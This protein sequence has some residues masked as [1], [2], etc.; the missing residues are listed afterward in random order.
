MANTRRGG[1]WCLRVGAIVGDVLR[2]CLGVLVLVACERGEQ[3]PTPPL[4]PSSP[5]ASVVESAP[6]ESGVRACGE[7]GATAME[8]PSRVAEG[9]TLV[10]R[11][12]LTPG[13]SLQIG[14]VA[15]RYDES[16]WIGTRRAGT[17]GPGLNVEI[18][19]AEVGPHAPWGTLEALRPAM[20]QALVVGPYRVVVQTGAEAP[21]AE[22]VVTVTREVCPAAAVIEHT[23]TPQWL[24]LSSEGIRVHSYDVAGGL[25]QVAMYPRG[26]EPRVEVTQRSYRHWFE[27]RPGADR[28]IRAGAYAVSFD[29]VLAGPGTRFEGRWVAETEAR[30][31]V[32]GR[33]EAAARASFPAAQ[34][35]ATPCGDPSPSRML[36]PTPLGA[37]LEIAETLRLR[38]GERAKMGPI[39][40]VFGTL[41]VPA[42]GHGVYRKEGYSVPNLQVFALHGGSNLTGP[43]PTARMLRV[44]QALLRVIGEGES[45]RVDRV[46]LACA[47]ELVVAKPTEPVYL[48]LGTNGH[49]YV[50]AG[51]FD[52]QALHLQVFLEHEASLGLSSER[53]SLIQAL[54]GELVGLGFTFD[55]HL[56]EVVEVQ[57][58]AAGPDGLPPA[59]HVQLRVT[60]GS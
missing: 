11:G 47:S 16:A 37:A 5:P 26:V 14:K 2:G 60:P 19:R 24:W 53:G 55:E 7:A 39:E 4:G 40:L 36:L 28:T 15:L 32:R 13:G 58:G 35:A 43:F 20:A 56:V 57:E 29:R 51:G 12:S 42:L 45:L 44:E 30:V 8:L 1:L 23:A 38:P 41:E 22:V 33:I 49:S 10:G 3:G 46:A 17:R 34:P 9:R 27:P 52:V 21:P 48:W 54:G 31:H 59:S 50:R 18:D 25:L 6:V